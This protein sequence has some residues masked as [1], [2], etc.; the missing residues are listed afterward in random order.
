MKIANTKASWYP[1]GV[2][3]VLWVVAFLNYLDRIL[4]TS[5]RDPIV[6]EFTLDDAQFGLLTSVFLWSYGFLSPFGGY[7]ADK[8]SR[9]KVIVFSVAVWSAVT[10][11]TGF[12]CSFQQ[13]LVARIFM[14]ISEAFYIPA[15]LAMISDY[16]KGRT[17][18]LATGIH[19]SG[20]YT[21]LALGGVGG[22][23]AEWWGWRYGFQVFG[24]FGC[25]YAVF[26]LFYLKDKSKGPVDN[27]NS[28]DNRERIGNTKRLDLQGEAET[29]DS[30]TAPAPMTFL[31]SMR[32]IL[33]NRS[34][35]VLL[36]YFVMLGIANWLIYGWLPTFLKDQFNLSLGEAGLSATGYVQIGSFIGV[37][38]GGILADRWFRTNQRSRLYMIIIGFSIGAPVLFLMSS[39]Y[40]F[41]IAIVAMIAFG[42]ARGFN[43]ANLMPIVHQV[44]DNRY[45]ATGYGLLNFLSTIVGGLMVYV[46]G[47]LKDAQIDL[48]VIYQGAA[49]LL[50]I[51]T[52][53]LFAV[54]IKK[55]KI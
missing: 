33:N 4:I 25:L 12:V 40:V 36:F 18:S 44:I 6:K 35:L 43:D 3:G 15:A 2:V 49:V 20:L 27:V 41:G 24:I 51:A 54:K 42:L 34:F 11:W 39:T 7:L 46:G 17:R 30:V 1:W 16:H 13:M 8:Y 21:G 52:W 14:G 29:P 55:D 31:S 48:S 50:L 37:I 22:F 53:S 26:I 10:V 19:F 45:V 47:A 32:L 38:A 9:K 28:I 23:I 5:M